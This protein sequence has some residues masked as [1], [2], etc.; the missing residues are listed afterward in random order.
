M[1]VEPEGSK[2]SSFFVHLVSTSLF[3]IIFYKDSF[4]AGLR[5]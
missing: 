5:L 2:G 1:L 3:K 4:F